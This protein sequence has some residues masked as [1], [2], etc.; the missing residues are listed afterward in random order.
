MDFVKY[1]EG[2]VKKTIKDYKLLTK[3]D[4]VIVAC[5]GGKDSTTVLYLLHKFGYDVKGMFVDLHIRRFSEINRKNL[6]TF[7]KQQKIKLH[8]LSFRKEFGCS[9]CYIQ[10][11]L[12]KQ[13]I[14]SCAVCG[15]LR[16]WLLNKKARELGATK[17]ATGHNL[18]DEAQNILMNASKHNPALSINLGPKTGVISDRKFVQRIKPL[19]F[20]LERES[21]KYSEL[22]KFPVLYERCPCGLPGYR[23]WFRKFL[24]ELGDETKVE[25]VNDFLK[26]LPEL[27]KKYMTKEKL[28]YCKLCGEP[29]RKDICKACFW[30]RKLVPPK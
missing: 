29:S 7:C 4:K 8:I 9:L 21:R 25:V 12:A 1:F 30:V 17:L 15:V 19:Y 18:D 3:K 26:R 2:K 13:K 5:S 11:A 10:S 27:R 20:C 28:A 23:T 16:R 22:M 6:E 14:K 24:N